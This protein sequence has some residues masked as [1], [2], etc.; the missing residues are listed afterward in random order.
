MYLDESLMDD[1]QKEAVNS[2]GHGKTVDFE[3][4]DL[5]HA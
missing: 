4:I 3:G 2:T 5:R 1:L